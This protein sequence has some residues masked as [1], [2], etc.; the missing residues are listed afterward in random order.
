MYALTVQE[1]QDGHCPIQP[2]NGDDAS[3]RTTVRYSAAL[4][5]PVSAVF[6]LTIAHYRGVGALAYLVCSPDRRHSCSAKTCA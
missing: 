4:S 3:M 2:A 5:Q 1:Q 6:V